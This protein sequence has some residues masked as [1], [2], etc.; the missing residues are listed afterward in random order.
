MI[1]GPTGSPT[2]MR[3]RFRGQLLNR[4]ALERLFAAVN[5]WP[6]YLAGVAT[7][8]M[9]AC[10]LIQV[11][12]RLAGRP[13]AWTEES[14]RFLFI[15]IVFLGIGAGFRKA[16]SPRVT[17]FV[18]KMPRSIRRLAPYIYA[19]TCLAFFLVVLITGSQ[20]VLQQIQ[21]HEMGSALLIPMWL[22]GAS[23]PASAVLGILGVIESLLLWPELLRVEEE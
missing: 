14:T 3:L 21:S 6:D 16:E 5:R 4:G 11:G 9:L 2:Q 20:L 13:V 22:V 17:Y 19:V 7:V 1:E 18:S 12:S 23:V 10:V 15:W 8:V